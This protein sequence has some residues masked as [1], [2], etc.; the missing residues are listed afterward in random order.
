VDFP[1]THAN[2]MRLDEMST[3]IR[4]KFHVSA[5]VPQWVG[6]PPPSMWG[7]GGAALR[8]GHDV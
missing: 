4:S 7:N 5:K 8:A 2:S 6:V 3:T 1:N